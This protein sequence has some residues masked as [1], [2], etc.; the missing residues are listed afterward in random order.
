MNKALADRILVVLDLVCVELLVLLNKLLQVLLH[1]IVRVDREASG[2]DSLIIL[3][4]E[5]GNVLTQLGDK[6]GQAQFA[7]YLDEPSIDRNGLWVVLKCKLAHCDHL[8]IDWIE[9][10]EVVHF[11][12]VETFK[13]NQDHI[14]SIL[15]IQ[16][17]QCLIDLDVVLMLRMILTNS[18][19]A[20][21]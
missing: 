11:H 18:H 21:C 4:V 20:R 13:C 7:V 5:L 3:I 6:R 14:F 2:T 1:A 9:H 8:E 17:A 16:I 12:L 15:S 10:S 19:L